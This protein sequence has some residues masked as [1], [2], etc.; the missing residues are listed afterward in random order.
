LGVH[1]SEKNPSVV[2][3]IPARFA[4]TR[5][6]GKPL[7]LLAGRPMILHVLDRVR[8]ARDVD[9]VVVLTDDER[10][11]GVVREAGGEVEM[12]P[13]DCA[14]GTDRI[15]W[16]ARSWSARSVINVQGDEPLMGTEAIEALARHLREAEDEMATLAVA[17]EPGDLENPNAVKVV[18]D[19]T[20]RA[21]YFSRAPIPYPRVAGVAPVYK[22]LGIYGYRRETLLRFASLPPVDLERAE[23]LEQ[24]RALHHGIPIRVLLTT[25][26]SW[27]VDTAEDAERVERLLHSTAT[28]QG[29]RA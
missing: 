25:A 7:R 23:S 19:G 17:A 24:L 29:G 5:L 3:A 1:P 10:I 16:A 2:V 28:T 12:T 20:G 9:R 26:N 8:A 22:H 21:L 11:A 4:A 13:E 15:A 18:L 27:G 14:S 6:P